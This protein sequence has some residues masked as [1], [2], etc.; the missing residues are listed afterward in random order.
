MF[1]ME[2]TQFDS[3]IRFSE[4][5]HTFKQNICKYVH[6]SDIIDSSEGSSKSSTLEVNTFYICMINFIII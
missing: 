1:H 3:E 2:N 6:S 4:A 5:L